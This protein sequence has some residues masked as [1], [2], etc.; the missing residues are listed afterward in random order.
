MARL[1]H[2][3]PGRLRHACTS[4]SW[5]LPLTAKPRFP[6]T[7]GRHLSDKQTIRPSETLLLGECVRDLALVAAPA[8]R[9][10]YGSSSRLFIMHP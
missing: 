3:L 9:Q 1:E 6:G 10:A 5:D 2:A 4:Q 8:Q 7:T